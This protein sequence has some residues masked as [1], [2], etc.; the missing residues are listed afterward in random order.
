MPKP[1]FADIRR[2][3]E[4]DG[5]ERTT[6]VRG[7]TGDHIRYR[8]VLPDGAIL[9]TRTSHGRDRIRDAGLWR[10]IWKDQLGLGNE[11]RFWEAL[12]AREPVERGLA[13]PSGPSL[14]GWLYRRLAV[15]VGVPEREIAAMS[16]DEARSRLS[17]LEARRGSPQ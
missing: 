17:E 10:R 9:R 6:G 5:W 15:D 4:I 13:P 2:F 7:K 3:C 16:I 8:K 14:P 11:E 1:T 12:R